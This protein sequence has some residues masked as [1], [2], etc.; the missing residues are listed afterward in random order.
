MFDAGR[1]HAKEAQGR[2]QFLRIPLSLSMSGRVDE[3]SQQEL[4]GTVCNLSAG[5]MMVELPV[6]MPPGCRMRA[7]LQT[8][9]GRLEVDGKIVWTVAQGVA[10]RHGIA[11]VEPKERDFA[12]DLF[13]AENR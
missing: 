3:P 9:Q 12:L 11:F 2:R 10:V 13:L 5:G 8:R 6:G 1:L 7:V 4:L